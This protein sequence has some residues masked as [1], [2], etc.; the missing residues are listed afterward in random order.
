MK[1]SEN[2]KIIVDKDKCVY[3]ICLCIYNVTADFNGQISLVATNEHGSDKCLIFLDVDGKK[4]YPIKYEYIFI[5]A[6]KLKIGQLPHIQCNV[7]DKVDVLVDEDV[8]LKFNVRSV[9]PQ[10]IWIEQNGAML[11]P[12]LV[13]KFNYPIIYLNLD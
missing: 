7:T 11:S 5:D 12:E 10:E 13:R 2:L 9:M 1:E 3:T 6:E 8:S 4:F